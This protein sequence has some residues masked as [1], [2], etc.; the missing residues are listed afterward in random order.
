MRARDIICF[1]RGSN[2]YQVAPAY[3]GV[4]YIGLRDGRIVATAPDRAGVMRSLILGN[5]WLR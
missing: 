5:K 2:L 3:E 1:W 4:G